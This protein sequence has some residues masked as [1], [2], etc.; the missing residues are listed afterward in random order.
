MQNCGVTTPEGGQH[1]PFHHLPLI[2]P[3][4]IVVFLSVL[5]VDSL[6]GGPGSQRRSSSLR[7]SEVLNET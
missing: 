7:A 2:S 6:G 5:L 1:R 4:H 3:A